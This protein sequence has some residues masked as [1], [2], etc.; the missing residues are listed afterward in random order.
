MGK[1]HSSSLVFDTPIGVCEH[2][3]TPLSQLDLNDLCDATDV[4]IAAGGGF[5]W[6]DIPAREILERFYQGVI[7]MPLREL[8]VAR[9]DGTI[10]GAAQ[11]IVPP[12]NN[13]AQKHSCQITGLFIAP[14]AR[15]YGLAKLMLERI[16]AFAKAAGFEVINLDV[17]ESLHLA[18]KLYE[19]AGYRL[20][21][22]H[23]FYAKV[24]KQFVAGRYY[25]KYLA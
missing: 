20:V 14:W 3:K 2:I 23:P 5:G 13:Q 18:I 25:M 11:I 8:F 19:G 12:S 9:L 6:L 21:G 22:E 16:E 24:G 4:A 1:N 15:G 7:A 10:C 17:R